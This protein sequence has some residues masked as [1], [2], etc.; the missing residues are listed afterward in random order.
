MDW[1]EERLENLRRYLKGA[2]LQKG[3]LL[4][5]LFGMIGAATLYV[6]TRNLC[7]S[8]LAV[9]AGTDIRTYGRV[10]ETRLLEFFLSSHTGVCYRL[11]YI[12]YHVCGYLYLA[13]AAVL[14]THLYLKKKILTAAASVEEAMSYIAVGDYSHEIAWYS[15][16]EMGGVCRSM[17]RMRQLLVE[18]KKRQWQ[19]EEAQRRVNA[20]FAHD[21]RTPL[22]VIKGN[23]EFLQRYVP[24]GKVTEEMLMEKLST[25][26]YQENRLLD[27]AGTMARIQKE[28][29]REVHAAWLDTAA[30][31][32]RLKNTGE[33]LAAGCPGN[34][35]VTGKKPR[36]DMRH[37]PLPAQIFADET[38]VEEVCD[39]L[40]SN[41]LRYARSQ[42]TVELEIRE[43]QLFLYVKDDGQGFSENALEKATE[44]YYSE[45]GSRSGETGTDRQAHFGIGLSVCKLLCEK[46]GGN[47]TL[48]NS[49]DGGGIA[50]A[51]FAVEWNGDM[52]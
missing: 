31:A 37:G 11:I 42:V 5:L 26:L 39:N 25:M 18:E 21:V 12:L 14:T 15:E 19:N 46:H 52:E 10:D 24:Q 28:E 41:A 23:T 43:R 32:E 30:F 9:L 13:L 40:L 48:I 22:T 33:T 8:W 47:V 17:E 34:G 45:A 16:D 20:A 38:I 35:V 27:F 49:V 3:I 50:C 7:E 6:L 29:A 36:F 51:T 4:Y 2:S 44:V 1:L